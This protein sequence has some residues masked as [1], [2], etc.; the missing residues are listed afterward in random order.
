MSGWTGVVNAAVN[1]EYLRRES[2]H[3]G[4]PWYTKSDVSANLYYSQAGSRVQPASVLSVESGRSHS[5]RVGQ[6]G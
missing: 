2:N 5:L 1:G 4:R 6:L 3:Q